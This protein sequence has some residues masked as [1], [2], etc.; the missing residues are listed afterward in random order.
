MIQ[1]TLADGQLLCGYHQQTDS[2]GVGCRPGVFFGPRRD[3]LNLITK[4]LHTFLVIKPKKL[5][6]HTPRVIVFHLPAGGEAPVS[7]WRRFVEEHYEDPM[8]RLQWVNLEQSQSHLQAD[9]DVFSQEFQ[10][11]HAERATLSSSLRNLTLS[12]RSFIEHDTLR[13]QWH[14]SGVN[15][16]FQA[17]LVHWHQ[18][19]IAA[20]SI[21]QST[22][23]FEEESSL[24]SW[25]G[26]VFFRISA[27]QGQKPAHT[28]FA[29]TGLINQGRAAQDR[30]PALLHSFYYGNEIA[31]LLFGHDVMDR[32]TWLPLESRAQTSHGA[33]D[34][35]I[36]W[37]WNT[38]QPIELRY[39]FGDSLDT[40]RE[41][42]FATYPESLKTRQTADQQWLSELKPAPKTL[43][44]ELQDLYHRTLL[45]LRQMQDPSG[46]IIAAPEFDFEF[47]NC[48]GYGFCW[49]RDAGFISYAMDI[50]GMHDESAKFYRYMAK[51]QSADGSFLHRHDMEGHLASSWGLLQPDETGSVIF[52][53][54]QHLQLSDNQA[55]ARDL[56]PMIEKAGNWLATARSFH[57]PHLPIEGTDLWEE[58]EGIHFYAVAAMTA[59][60]KS[61]ID[62][63]QYMG[64]EAPQAWQQRYSE[65]EGSLGDQT[66]F[67]TDGICLRTLY[68]NID[69][70]TRG[71]LEQIGIRVRSAKTP[72]GR[73]RYYAD[74][75]STL[76]ISQ[77][78]ALYPYA[79]DLGERQEIW[80]TMIQKMMTQLWRKGVGGIGR[81][82]SDPYRGGNPWILTTLWLALAAAQTEQLD[83]ARQCWQW[84][85]SHVSQEGLFPEQID[86]KTGRPSW[87]M[88]LTWSHA[89]FALAIHQLPEDVKNEA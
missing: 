47:E 43:A 9:A 63:Y 20:S 68:R 46:G 56:H 5:F 15:D 76:D 44:P 54:W 71:R 78:G 41:E 3:A 80:P 50:C 89:M 58:R 87:V 65:L 74:H 51:C 7:G 31:G 33:T 28:V 34:G 12:I 19:E 11:A 82:E 88:P 4:K 29:E 52:G 6:D 37:A 22:S 62:I 79:L 21:L 39:R 14:L 53:L 60:L 38:Q 40:V 23:F 70:Q 10:V 13:E 16:E 1:L 83:I 26:Q 77:L 69:N 36:V 18:P 81:Y 84:V 49:G 24:I 30:I 75:D 32:G 48:G 45:T 85:V 27:H 25:R 55:L 61:A 86:P 59:G 67:T 42:P 57:D 73:Y 8:C 17:W 72:N 66:F 35:T 2:E 64:W